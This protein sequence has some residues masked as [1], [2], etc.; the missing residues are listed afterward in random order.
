M[1]KKVL[2]NFG[3]DEQD[4]A[5][6]LPATGSTPTLSKFGHVESTVW[7]A[8]RVTAFRRR[9]SSRRNTRR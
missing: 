9:D 2:S 4:D 1:P 3:S 5:C 8:Q 7:S 6:P